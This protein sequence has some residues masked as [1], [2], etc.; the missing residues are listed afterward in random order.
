MSDRPERARS[1]FVLPPSGAKLELVRALDEAL[2]RQFGIGEVVILMSHGE[3]QRDEENAYE[4]IVY[5]VTHVSDVLA[6]IRRARFTVTRSIQ[7]FR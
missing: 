6:S 7:R 1:I 5:D 2:I 4:V 3:Y